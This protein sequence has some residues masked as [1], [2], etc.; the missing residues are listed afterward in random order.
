[1]I[2]DVNGE[3]TL[4]SVMC[5]MWGKVVVPTRSGSTSAVP[6]LPD[7]ILFVDHVLMCVRDCRGV[8]GCLPYGVRRFVAASDEKNR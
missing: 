6:E 3:M 4:A 5:P 2:A 8:R 1:M 7:R